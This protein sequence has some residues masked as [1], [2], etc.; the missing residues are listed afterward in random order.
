ME[1]PAPQ[2]PWMTA[3]EIA[4][5]IV[6]PIAGVV[7]A[8]TLFAANRRKEATYILVATIVG[9]LWLVPLLASVM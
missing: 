5:A 7:I 3:L 4:L 2:T 9:F 6:L 8:L 1:Q